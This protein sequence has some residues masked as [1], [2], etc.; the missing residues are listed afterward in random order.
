MRAIE[1]QLTSAR[2]IRQCLRG[3]SNPEIAEHSARFFKTGKGEYG[4]GDRFLGIRVPMLRQLVRNCRTAQQPAVL[5]LLRS[6]F[7]EERLFALLALV[8]RA[9]LLKRHCR[10]MPRNDAALRDRAPAA[11]QTT[12]LPSTLS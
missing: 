1:T 9:R 3:L 4:E 6:P 10:R 12:S 7:H 8:D 5:S 11:S 2:Q